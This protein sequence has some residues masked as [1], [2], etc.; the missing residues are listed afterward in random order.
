M[1]AMDIVVLAADVGGTNTKIALAQCRAARC[2][3]IKRNIY[4]SRTYARLEDVVDAFLR[5]A[6]VAPH[7][8]HVAAACLAVAGP[9]ENGGARLTNLPWHIDELELARRFSF[10]RASVINDFAAA[11]HGIDQLAESDLLTLQSGTALP[12]ADR[13]VI[14]AGTGL[15]VAWLV[16]SGERYEVHPSEG[17]HADFA[18][19]DALQ[20]ELLLYLRRQFGRVSY[21]R[22]LSGSGLMRI[23]SFLKERGP[24]QPTPALL[25]AISHG[26]PARAITEFAL[27]GRDAL[28]GRALDVFASA[29]GA[30]A[31]NMALT[32]LAHGGIYVAGGIAPKIA[33]KLQDGT[34]MRAFTDKGRFQAMLAAIPVKVVMNDQVGLLG[35]VAE[36]A[37]LASA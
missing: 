16:C 12:D 37:R 35:A 3:I 7:A 8:S 9:V 17:G 6:D 2:T 26:E 23:F 14:G 32:G 10:G 22:V 15:G 21:E 19:V 20:D 36:A 33:A 28:A 4:P 11:G 29:Y 30:F 18:P 24:E 1:M 5:E 31:G 34:F 25:E 13:I 27:A